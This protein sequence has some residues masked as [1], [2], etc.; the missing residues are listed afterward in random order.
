MEKEHRLSAAEISRLLELVSSLAEERDYTPS[1]AIDVIAG[2]IQPERRR[3][4]SKALLADYAERVRRVRM[5]RNDV[6]GAP[7]FRDP[8]WDMLL[9]LFSAHGRGR[10]VSVSSLCYASGVPLTTALRQLSRLEEHG[11]VVREGDRNDS[12]RDFVRP[13]EKAIAGIS[14]I[15]ELLIE[16]SQAVDG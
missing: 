8:A 12:R 15:A 3:S 2:L 14:S 13:T 11:M 7:L 5:R 16:E 6:V 9:A 10:K 1:E 4:G